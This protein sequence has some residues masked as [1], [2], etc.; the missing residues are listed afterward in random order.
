MSDR[1]KTTKIPIVERVLEAN[2]QLAES[3]R[4]DLARRG[5][6]AVDIIGAPG[7]GKTALLEATLRALKGRRHPAVLVGDLATRRDGDRLARWCDQVVQISTGQGCHLEANQ[8]RDALG[9]IDLD[10]VDLLFIEN[11]GNLICP[12]GFDLGQAA[13]VETHRADQVSHVLDEEQVHRVQVDLAERIADLVRLQVTPLAVEIWTTWSHQRARR[14]P[15]RRVARSPTRTAGRRCPLRARSVASR[16]AVL[17]LP[18]APIRSTEKM[19]RRSSS[20]RL[21]AAIW[22]FASR[23]RSTSG[24][25]VVRP[26]SGIQASSSSIVSATRS[27]SS[28][29]VGTGAGSPQSQATNGTGLVQVRPQVEH[30]MDHGR[31]STR[32]IAPAMGVSWVT[33]SQPIRSASGSSPRS[34]PTLISTSATRPEA[35]A[36]LC[37]CAARASAIE[38]SCTPS[39]VARWAGRAPGR[40]GPSMSGRWA[41][42][43]GPIYGL[44]IMCR[45]I[46]CALEQ[47]SSPTGRMDRG[48]RSG[49]RS[50]APGLDGNGTHP[51]RGRR[52]GSRRAQRGR[53]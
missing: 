53:A 37:T 41:C 29:A 1:V 10:A 45:S 39:I 32:R 38:I 51:S 33:A 34:A 30:V 18:G 25:R 6:F 31:R 5:I 9:Q 23:T 16:S 49:R 35:G 24:T 8:V 7:S 17:P 28:P 43:E 19:A 4:A 2:D 22:L 52:R 21:S 47:H 48:R 50:A 15:S 26:P 14:S 40:L 13:K 11:V 42:T 46:P 20:A 27:S 36:W 44:P 12:V 3:V